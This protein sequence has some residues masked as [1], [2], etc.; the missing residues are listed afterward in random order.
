VISSINISNLNNSQ[1][2]SCWARQQRLLSKLADVLSTK[3][4][5]QLPFVF[6]EDAIL[7]TT[8]A[9]GLAVLTGLDEI[10]TGI[11]FLQLIIITQTVIIGNTF[12]D[13]CPDTVRVQLETVQVMDQILQMG[14]T[15]LPCILTGASV[16]VDFTPDK[17]R[18]TAFTMLPG[19]SQIIISPQV[20]GANLPIVKKRD[21]IHDQHMWILMQQWIANAISKGQTRIVTILQNTPAYATLS[22][23]FS[24]KKINI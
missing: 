3:D 24:T 14:D 15:M 22:T 8:E 6:T 9:G 1:S 10:T 2:T 4:T 18:I 16:V 11:E 5:S 19:I 7:D 20:N 13:G 12:D 17:S 23:Q 21:I